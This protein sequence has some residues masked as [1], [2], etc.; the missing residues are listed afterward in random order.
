MGIDAET[1]TRWAL[2]D[3]TNNPGEIDGT[4]EQVE[5]VVLAQLPDTLNAFAAYIDDVA[6]QLANSE[7][8]R[9]L[10]TDITMT[11]EELA[12]M[13]VETDRAAILARLTGSAKSIC[14]VAAELDRKS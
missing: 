13:Y 1:E 6:Q 2:E 5:A 9:I 11:S 4:P 3:G 8:H 12:A 10:M 14:S 7:R